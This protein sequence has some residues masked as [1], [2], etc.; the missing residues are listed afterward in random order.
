[1]VFL[2]LLACLPAW[3]GPFLRMDMGNERTVVRRRDLLLSFF[4]LPTFGFSDAGFD[5]ACLGGPSYTLAC[6][7]I[8]PA[9]SFYLAG[10]G[11]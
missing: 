11:R 6:S 10:C 2:F 4:N 1:M 3:S 9:M 5:H 7:F 8:Y